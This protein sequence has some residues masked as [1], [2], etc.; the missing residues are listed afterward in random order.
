MADIRRAMLDEAADL[1]AGARNVT[2]GDYG[3]EAARIGRLW[4]AILNRDDIPARTVAAMMIALKVA[5]ATAG[6]ANRDDWTDIAGYAALACQID[7]D[8][9]DPWA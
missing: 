2:H 9:G 4:G 1:V 7:F 8:R 5:R 6:A 3:V